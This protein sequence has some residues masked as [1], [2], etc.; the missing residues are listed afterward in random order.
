MCGFLLICLRGWKTDISVSSV[1]G[2]ETSDNIIVKHSGL[3]AY[4]LFWGSLMAVGAYTS[5]KY[6]SKPPDSQQHLPWKAFKVMAPFLAPA[7]PGSSACLT[8][9][10][11]ST[12]SLSWVLIPQ[13]NNSVPVWE[14][15]STAVSQPRGYFA[16]VLCENKR[17]KFLK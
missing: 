4:R 14:G 12:F 1:A 11:E 7:Q 15:V 2:M 8:S 17:S 3:R 16:I 10:Q 13:K 5:G 9:Q 6:E